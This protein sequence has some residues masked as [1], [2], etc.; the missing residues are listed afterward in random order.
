[1]ATAVVLGQL[2]RV[3]EWSPELWAS[4]RVLGAEQGDATGKKAGHWGGLYSRGAGV[5]TGDRGR[6]GVRAR[7]CSERAPECQPASNTWE[8]PSAMVQWLI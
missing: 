4:S 7:A 5:V 2:W 6:A 8:L 1:L 3:A